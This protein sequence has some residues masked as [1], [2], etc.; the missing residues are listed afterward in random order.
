MIFVKHAYLGYQV[1]TIYNSNRSKFI[2]LRN[3]LSIF[4]SLPRLMGFIREEMLGKVLVYSMFLKGYRN[5]FYNA[6]QLLNGFPGK[7]HESPRK[8]LHS[9]RKNWNF[10][11]KS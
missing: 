10:P 2:N 1:D 4:L 9:P 6:S 11:R 5:Y 8:T 7:T 3:E